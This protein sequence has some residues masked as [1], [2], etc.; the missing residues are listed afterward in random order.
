[1]PST[2]VSIV[3][4]LFFTPGICYVKYVQGNLSNLM[5]NAAMA[6]ATKTR[7]SLSSSRSTLNRT[8]IAIPMRQKLALRDVFMFYCRWLDKTNYIYMSRTQFLRMCRDACLMGPSLDAVALTLLFEKVHS[9][10]PMASSGARISITD[11][12]IALGLIANRLFGYESSPQEAFDK[13][14]ASG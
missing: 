12:I 3:S 14:G 2:A 9:Q 13:V 4:A 5:G 11:W 8:S 6:H 10:S 1:M 7:S